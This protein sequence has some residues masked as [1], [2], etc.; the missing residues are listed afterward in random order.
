M[1]KASLNML[2]HT[3]AAQLARDNIFMHSIDPGWISQ[4]S[5]LTNTQNGKKLQQLL[6]LDLLDAAA[7]ICDPTFMSIKMDKAPF[8]EAV[9]L[10]P[11]A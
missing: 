10:I 3:A 2:T 8:G 9:R 4:Q 1:A 11:D 7:R 5:P 6:P